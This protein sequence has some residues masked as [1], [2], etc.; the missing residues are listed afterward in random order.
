DFGQW[1]GQTATIVSSGFADTAA[2]DDGAR[3]G[4]FIVPASGGNFIAM[5][6]ETVGINDLKGQSAV[7]LYPNPAQDIV[8]I[9]GLSGSSSLV[10]VLDMAGRDLLRLE[11]MTETIDISKLAPGLYTIRVTEGEYTWFGKITKQ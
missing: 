5:T 10:S 4:L 3:F 6:E 1:A 7:M 11:G 8:H 2:N 9:K